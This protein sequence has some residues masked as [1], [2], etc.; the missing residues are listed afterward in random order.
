[1]Q[2]WSVL[3]LRIRSYK[4][5]LFCCTAKGWTHKGYVEGGKEWRMAPLKKGAWGMH[6]L[7]PSPRWRLGCKETEELES[8]SQLNKQR[9]H[10][11]RRSLRTLFFFFFS[12]PQEGSFMSIEIVVESSYPFSSFTRYTIHPASSINTVVSINLNNKMGITFVRY[13]S[14]TRMLNRSELNFKF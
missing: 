10:R 7:S 1:M 5:T 13:H 12:L 2:P 8:N 3:P 14:V 4:I 9:H 11:H 6:R